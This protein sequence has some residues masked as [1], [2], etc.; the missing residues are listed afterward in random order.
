MYYFKIESKLK[1]SSCFPFTIV[2][3][4]KMLPYIVYPNVPKDDGNSVS[5]RIQHRK[6]YGAEHMSGSLKPVS[7]GASLA[8]VEMFCPIHCRPG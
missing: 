2:I 6:C 4:S 5:Y 3:T 8:K 1:F 7:L